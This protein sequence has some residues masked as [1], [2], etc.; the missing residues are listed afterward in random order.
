MGPQSLPAECESIMVSRWPE[1]DSAL[2]FEK[3]REITGYVID[4][5]K[6]VRS[7]RSQKNVAPGLK[8][9]LYIETPY[10][11]LFNESAALIKRLAGA[12]EVNVGSR[13]ELKNTVTAISGGAK[14]HIPLSQ[15]VDR[16]KEGARLAAQRKKLLDEIERSEEKLA[17]KGFTEKAP[18]KLIEEERQKLEK[19]RGMLEA[20]EISIKELESL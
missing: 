10:E 20:L 4:A 18:R 13:F 12:S 17:N 2:A 9:A 8:P 5:V 6:A 14:I 3:E 16:E 11:A 1:Y 15:L 7:L 19:N